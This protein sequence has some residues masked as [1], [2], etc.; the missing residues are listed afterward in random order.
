MLTTFNFFFLRRRF[1][2]DTEIPTE[3][4]WAIVF[5]MHRIAP[6]VLTTVIG[7]V[8]SCLQV[9]EVDR[10]LCVVKLLGRLF[11]SPSSNIG[12]KFQSCFMSWSKRVAD[13]DLTIRKQMARCMVKILENKPELKE[14]ATASIIKLLND[15]SADIRVEIVH[16]VC[17]LASEQPGKVSTDLLKAIGGR[18][19]SKSKV[20]RKDAA[21]GLAQIYQT[22][23]SKVVLSAID[24]DENCDTSDIIACVTNCTTT[25]KS[26]P[27]TVDYSWIPEVVFKAFSFTDAVDVEMRSRVVQIVDDVL[28]PKSLSTTARAT[29]LVIIL[30]NLTVGSNGY[31]WV[32]K[33]L[34]ERSDSQKMLASYLDSR[35]KAREFEAGSSGFLTENANSEEILEKLVNQFAPMAN[36]EA[37]KKQELL[38]KIH[39]HKDKHIF[40]LMATICDPNHTVGARVRALDELPKRVNSLGNVASTWMKSFVRRVSNGVS[41]CAETIG[42]CA[43]LAHEC[44]SSDDFESS[45]LFLDV[46]K[47]GVISFP[48]FG[49]YKDA[50]DRS[51]FDHIIEFFNECSKHSAKEKKEAAKFN[52][53]TM[54]SQI[55]AAIA[56]KAASSS[57]FNL[58][59]LGKND[60]ELQSQLLRLCTKEGTPEQACHAIYVIS[61]LHVNKENIDRRQT[62]AMQ[63]NAFGP[64][65]KA[66][67]A[68][69]RLS[70]END[71]CVSILSALTALAETAPHAFEAGGDGSQEGRGVKAV[72]F[73]LESVILGKRGASLLKEDAVDDDSE[74]ESDSEDDSE[75]KKKSTKKTKKVNLA[76]L[77]VVAAIE[78]LTAHICSLPKHQDNSVDML[79][80]SDDVTSASHVKAVFDVF[81]RIVKDNGLPPNS[82]DRPSCNDK[83][84]K[85]MIRKAVGVGL[86]RLCSPNGGRDT[87]LTLA[88]YNEL[89]SLL[90]DDN[91]EVRNAVTEELTNMIT[92][93]GSYSKVA[94]NLRFVGLGVLTADAEG[95]VGSVVASN[96]SAVNIGKKSNAA[97]QAIMKCI[98]T[99]RNTCDQ[100][101]L[102][103]KSKGEGGEIFFEKNLKHRCMPEFALPFALHLLANRE[104]T[105]KT[106][107]KADEVHFKQLKR[108][109][110]NLLEPLIQSLGV[111][112]DNISFLLRMTELVAYYELIAFEGGADEEIVSTKLKVVCKATRECILKY[113]KTDAHLT[114]YPGLIQIPLTLFSVK[115]DT[116]DTVEDFAADND[117]MIMDDA[118]DNWVESP[119]KSSIKSPVKSV[120]STPVQSPGAMTLGSRSANTTPRST[121]K[122][123]VSFSKSP[124]V[125][126][127]RSNIS[128][129]SMSAVE[130]PKVAIK[131]GRTST[132]SVG[133]SASSASSGSKGGKGKKRKTKDKDTSDFDF[134]DDLAASVDADASPAPKKGK[135]AAA[136]AKGAKAGKG[137]KA[138]K[139]KKTKKSVKGQ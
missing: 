111:N 43:M 97:K 17:D 138:V 23:Y 26:A 135:K 73:A 71:R 118:N 47:L 20:E 11:Y 136:G 58:S 56:P 78:L 137:V 6:A 106:T 128:D 122:A 89:A 55:M 88:G 5:E 18:I 100:V 110:K 69:Q 64:L 84:S 90:L 133:S 76:P 103:C 40:K 113:V 81:L 10:R 79:G 119:I 7:N 38:T 61:A 98:D 60:E 109:L 102:Q 126:A 33:F 124:K 131:M 34:Q 53:V 27:D 68:P 114:P 115:G 101:L 129:L 30:S 44:A 70:L 99:L 46:C 36:V 62:I 25:K 120:R 91:A 80:T 48:E 49:T 82:K 45:K 9:E 85:A 87:F 21:T 65:L 1:L 117:D 94:P 52:I 86:M 125:F 116:T 63:Q 19:A 112:A 2:N 42:H 24:A 104:E 67:T 4:I 72:R 83:A 139:G 22:H 93:T 108:R 14:H 121:T 51:C 35:D 127:N 8:T 132:D 134:E 16:N 41:I 31:K 123:K 74:S 57:N 92:G 66:L 3:T 95:S 29:G 28:L 32:E 39:N 107:G 130:K 15:G 96:G 77:R 59:A 105:P 37:G 75:N 54:L 13:V 50:D 12:S